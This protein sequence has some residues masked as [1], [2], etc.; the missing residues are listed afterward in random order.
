MTD[1]EKLFNQVAQRFFEQW[2]FVTSFRE[3]SKLGIKRAT[4]DVHAFEAAFVRSLVTDP[5]Y[6]GLIADKERFVREGLDR[7]FANE[8]SERLLV[9]AAT[10]YNAACLVFAHSVLDGVALDYCKVTALAS[11]TDWESY[12]DNRQIE[13]KA[14]RSRKYEELLRDALDA[15]FKQLERDSVLKKVDLLFQRCKPTPGFSIV[16]GFKFDRDR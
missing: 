8:I 14:V 4:G 6:A 2:G 13:L 15:F 5:A 7:R 16:H 9:D 12:F 3:L 11:P 1:A 10:A